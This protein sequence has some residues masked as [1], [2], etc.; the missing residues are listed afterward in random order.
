MD[1]EKVAISAGYRTGIKMAVDCRQCAGGQCAEEQ[2][3]R[4]MME[5]A[6]RDASEMV[7]VARLNVVACCADWRV[8]NGNITLQASDSLHLLGEQENLGQI[9]ELTGFN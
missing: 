8:C 5:E 1:E 6:K 4:E 3:G 9:D 7:V 2:K